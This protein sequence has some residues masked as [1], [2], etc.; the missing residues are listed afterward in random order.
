MG[1]QMNSIQNEWIG[2]ESNKHECTLCDEYNFPLFLNSE[3][4][5][6]NTIC[7]SEYFCFVGTDTLKCGE[8]PPT[9][10]LL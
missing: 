6:N 1:I 3:L 5:K 4:G 8:A 9:Q 10:K 2:L 7:T